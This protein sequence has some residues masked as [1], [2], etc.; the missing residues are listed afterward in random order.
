MKYFFSFFIVLTTTIGF[1]QGRFDTIEIKSEKLSDNVY[2]L[3]GAG[4]NIGVSVG[5]DGVF[6]I[7]DQFAPLSEKILAKIK[8]LSDKPLKF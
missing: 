6:V 5:E 8:T 2:V 4:G 1:S 3:F 7:D